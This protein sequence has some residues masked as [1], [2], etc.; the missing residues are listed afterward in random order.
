[1]LVECNAQDVTS[2]LNTFQLGSAALSGV[3]LAAI[4]RKL[5]FIQVFFL[6]KGLFF[7]QKSG[8]RQLLALMLK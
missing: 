2:A 5:E 7:S 8:G 4:K 3:R 6:K 1:M